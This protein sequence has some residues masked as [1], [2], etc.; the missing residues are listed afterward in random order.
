MEE[1]AGAASLPRS[2]S[3]APSMRLF[4]IA[5]SHV[6]EWWTFVRLVAKPEAASTIL[7]SHDASHAYCL[8]CNVNI[9]LRVGRHKVG[10]H[11]IQVHQKEPDEIRI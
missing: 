4:E 8:K 1:A 5:G 10:E 11:M 7:T 2:A 3:T 6:K 9:A